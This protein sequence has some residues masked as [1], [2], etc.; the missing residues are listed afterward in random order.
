MTDAIQIGLSGGF[1]GCLALAA[2]LW[3]CWRVVRVSISAAWALLCRVWG[4]ERFGPPFRVA[5]LAAA[6]WAFSAPLVGYVQFIETAYLN[7][8]Y[9]L[10]SPLDD[11]AKIAIYEDEIR[12]HTTPAEFKVVQDSTRGTAARIG[13]TPLAIYEAAF[14]ECGL[15]PF[16]VRS[17]QVAAGWIQIT[18]AGCAR[19]GFTKAQVIEACRRRD[20]GF[21][22]ATAD[23]YLCHRAARIPRGTSL[24]N[25]IDLY[26]AIFAPA[27]IGA[28]AQKV[29]Y[30][31]FS[32]PAYYK[33]SG[34]D[35]W[36]LENGK[37]VRGEKDGKITA[38]EIFLCL[39]RKKAILFKKKLQ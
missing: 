18:N 21:V 2:A 28:D 12:R 17:D 15:K 35:G 19:L 24:V 8:V 31:G 38:F 13:S 4:P 5:L 14:L 16:E 32:N 39:E 36:R 37:I 7:P 23:T 20:I 11:Q 25:T 30:A 26:L 6:L 34:L 22:M 27:H 1:L 29:V 3:L 9:L 10:P 33:N